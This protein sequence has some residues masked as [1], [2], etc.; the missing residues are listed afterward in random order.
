MTASVAG[1]RPD[2][3]GDWRWPIDP[4]RYDTTSVLRATEKDAIVELGVDNLRRL[5]RHDPAARGWQQIRRLLRP[6][7]DAADL[8]SA[9]GDAGR[10]CG[11]AAAVR[12]DRPVLLVVDG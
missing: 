11:G 7:D 6:L 2:R 9:P 1:G 3:P 8:P 12:R 10:D 5:A 4:G